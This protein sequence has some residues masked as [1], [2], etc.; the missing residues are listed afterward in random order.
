MELQEAIKKRQTCRKFRDE[1]VPDE[2]I[3][4]I[5]N[6]MRLAPS[7]ENEQNWHFLIVRNRIFLEHLEKLI[8]GG[9]N[10]LADEVSEV[11]PKKGKRFA[12]F[13]KLFTLFAFKA[14]VLIIIYSRTVPNCATN[15]YILLGR[16]QEMIDELNVRSNAM[17]SV[18][19][20][21]EHGV[22]TATELG[23]GSAF[24]TSPNFMHEKIE[25]LIAEELGFSMPGWYLTA[26]LPVGKPDG[27]MK[28]PNRK[29]LEELTDVFD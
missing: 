14:P 1:P 24:M 19:A 22:L 7:S 29:P 28:S 15:E 26:F 11:D 12:K 8:A 2:D 5:L 21:I 18:G 17:M 25:N 4:K 16:P 3:R 23:Y 13:S 9:M 6:A 20:A 10:A 27:P